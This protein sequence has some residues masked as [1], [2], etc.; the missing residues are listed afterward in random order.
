MPS[1]RYSV[2]NITATPNGD[3]SV[4]VHFGSDD[5]RPNLLPIMDRW[6]YIIGRYRLRPEVL[7]G[8]RTLASIETDQTKIRGDVRLRGDAS[9]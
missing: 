4:T 9:R 3:G 6:N 2:N 8:S 5:D 7:D 1:R